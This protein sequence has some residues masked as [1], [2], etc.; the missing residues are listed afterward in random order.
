MNDQQL[1]NKIRQ[2]AGKVK[3]DL[4]TLAGDSATQL[5]GFEEKVS[6]ASDKAKKDLTAWAE[7]GI[8]QLNKRFGRFSQHAQKTVAV[9]AKTVK[10]D[11]GQGLSQYDTKVKDV[12]AK[13]PGN[14]GKKVARYPWVAISIGLVVGFLLGSLFKP[15]PLGQPQ[16]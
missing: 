10:E 9:T 6:Q 5:S 12:A 1:E 14:F 8:T 2:D 11:V 4:S 13:I 15:A 7:D 3:K 16:I